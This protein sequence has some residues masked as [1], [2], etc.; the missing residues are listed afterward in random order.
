LSSV[1]FPI[2]PIQIVSS[3]TTKTQL[4]CGTITPPFGWSMGQF[5]TKK[6]C[7][8]KNAWFD[9]GIFTSFLVD[10]SGKKKKTHMKT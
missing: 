2:C 10:T 1:D 4:G 6:K 7:H 9:L 3:L 8:A 5:S